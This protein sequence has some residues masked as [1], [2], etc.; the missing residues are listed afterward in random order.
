[1][2]IKAHTTLVFLTILAA[3]FP[4]IADKV[5]DDI[6]RVFKYWYGWFFIVLVALNV[7]MVVARI[8]A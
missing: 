3:F 5:C 8:W 2:L 4:K 1:M 7:A 6:S